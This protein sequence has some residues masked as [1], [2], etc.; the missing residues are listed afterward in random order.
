MKVKKEEMQ[1]FLSWKN[2]LRGNNIVC[3]SKGWRL[4]LQESGLQKSIL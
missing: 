2:I 4:T 3:G 1:I